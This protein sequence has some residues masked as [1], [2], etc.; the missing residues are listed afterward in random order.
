MLKRYN[1]YRT[2]SFSVI[3]VFTVLLLAGCY[4]T[5]GPAPV[6][7]LGLNSGGINNTV[8]VRKHD[9]VWRIS[10]RFRLPLQ[11]IVLINDLKAPYALNAGQRI[12]LPEPKEYRVGEQDTLYSI[13]R[14]FQVD[15][16]HLVRLNNLRAPY[17]L[18]AGQIL[19][20]PSSRHH[21][22][23]PRQIAPRYSDYKKPER[24]Y[25]TPRTV[26]AEKPAASFSTRQ[27]KQP[28]RQI[29]KPRLA[30]NYAVKQSQHTGFIWPV[31]GRILSGFGPKSGGGFFLGLGNR[32]V[33]RQVWLRGR[34][35]FR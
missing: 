35:V 4:Q 32:A 31:R 17:R 33:A 34:C 24:V 21:V 22:S 13:S 27:T 11:D 28:P 12:R 30:K 19:R 14:V 23:S 26:T 7:K 3:F 15:L 10:K 9:T 5:S 25:K 16:N 6:A 1:K 8:L 2:C 18:H 20:L 29:N